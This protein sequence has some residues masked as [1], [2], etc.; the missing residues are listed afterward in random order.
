MCLWLKVHSEMLY[1][2]KLFMLTFKAHTLGQE[3]PD[4]NKTCQ[5]G[6]SFHLLVL[7]VLCYRPFQ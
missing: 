5:R 6:H 1:D 3:S 4:P 7:L 2:I